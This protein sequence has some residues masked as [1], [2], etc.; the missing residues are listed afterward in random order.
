VFADQ[1][2]ELLPARTTMKSVGHRHAS[3][4]AVAPRVTNNIT[5]NIV[6]QIFNINNTQ[7]SLGDNSPNVSI[8]EI[9][10]R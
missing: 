1:T 5:F 7:V 3:R 4:Y 8:I 9:A 10:N 2:V 6:F